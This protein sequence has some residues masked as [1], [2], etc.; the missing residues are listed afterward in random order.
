[1][2][3]TLFIAVCCSAALASFVTACFM[4]ETLNPFLFR[5]Q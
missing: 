1:M 3:G 5:G 4:Y 2:L